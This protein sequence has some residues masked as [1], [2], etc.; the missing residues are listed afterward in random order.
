MGTLNRKKKK[1]RQHITVSAVVH[2]FL[3]VKRGDIIMRIRE[4]RFVPARE[5]RVKVF[6]T[7]APPILD[8][9]MARPAGC[10]GRAGIECQCRRA[11]WRDDRPIGRRSK[12]ASGD[13]TI[14]SVTEVPVADV[15]FL[16]NHGCRYGKFLLSKNHRVRSYYL[17]NLFLSL[18]RSQG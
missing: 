18:S 1:R 3:C 17:Q 14:A 11:T 7:S 13:E 8:N 2:A 15:T 10:L 9:A 5:T 4:K 16:N 6:S 12:A